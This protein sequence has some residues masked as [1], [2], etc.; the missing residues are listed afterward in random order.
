M[1]HCICRDIITATGIIRLH[2][3][4]A[5]KNILCG[6]IAKQRTSEATYS[7]VKRT[8]CVSTCRHLSLPFTAETCLHCNSYKHENCHYFLFSLLLKMWKVLK[9]LMCI[10]FTF[11][12]SLTYHM[13]FYNRNYHFLVLKKRLVDIE[14]IQG[15]SIWFNFLFILFF[16]MN[17]SA[18]WL[19]YMTLMLQSDVFLVNEN[20]N[21]WGFNGIA[22]I[23][24]V[25]SFFKY[26]CPPPPNKNSEIK[27]ILI[28]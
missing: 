3:Q 20:I 11:N 19:H 14:I 23:R 15:S 13:L 26:L 2:P 25:V 18:C 27:S 7:W 8:R 1:V 17:V 12:C 24:T 28:L 4:F 5:K 9:K 22:I 10:L 16:F 21:E 6:F